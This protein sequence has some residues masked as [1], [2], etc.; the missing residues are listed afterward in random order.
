MVKGVY[1]L[2]LVVLIY[3]NINT[4]LYAKGDDKYG[5]TFK[6]HEVNKD[7][8]T[9][10]NLTPDATMDLS[11]GFELDFDLKL[12]AGVHTYGY[13]FRLI[14][15]DT[16]SLDMVTDINLNQLN[17]ILTDYNHFEALSDFKG[18]IKKSEWIK[19]VF[20]V[21]QDSIHYS[22]DGVSR[23]IDRSITDFDNIKIYFGTN[24][25]ENFYT[26]DLPP[27]AV[28]NIVIKDLDSNILKSWNMGRH[29]SDDV[30]DIVENDRAVAHNGI[31]E[32]DKYANWNKELSIKV[33][34]EYPQLAVDSVNAR[35]FVVKKDSIFIIHI[36]DKRIE[37]IGTKGGDPYLQFF[38]FL[39]YDQNKDRLV[40]YNIDH[41][42]LIY[43][44]FITR[45]WNGSKLDQNQKYMYHNKLVL[46]EKNQLVTFGGYGYYKYSAY[47]C[48]HDLDGAGWDKIDL[49]KD[50]YPRYLASMG[51][52]GDDKLLVFGGYGS[53]SGIQ[54]E[55]ARNLYD[56]FQI[57]LHDYKCTKLGE[58][59]VTASPLAFSNSMII[60]KKHQ[61]FYTLSYSNFNYQTYIKLTEVNVNNLEY[62]FLADSIPYKFTDTQAYCDLFRYNKSQTLYSLVLQKDLDGLYDLS[63]YSVKY[64]ALT[65]AEVTI[66]AKTKNS[67]NYILVLVLVIVLV[68]LFV[69][70]IARKKYLHKT[71]ENTEPEKQIIK[72]PV[73]VEKNTSTIK[74]LGGY[75]VFDKNGNDISG[76]FTP[77]L[78]QIFLMCLLDTII[79]GKG[80]TSDFLD[81]ELWY[82]MDKDKAANNRR[83]NFSKL[84]LLLHEVGDITLKKKNG[85]WQVN[86][87]QDVY[88]DFAEIMEEINLLKQSDQIDKSIVDNIISKAIKGKLIPNIS[89][90]WTD[91]Y[92]SYYTSIIIENMM[93]LAA[94]TNIKNDLK[95]LVNIAEVILIHDNIDEEAIHL[96]CNSLYKLGQKGLSK[97]CFEKYTADYKTLLNEEPNL[98]YE[99]LISD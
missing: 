71:P 74:L 3:C 76:Q 6:S 82:D 80:V 77:I 43:F 97:Q 11:D 5:L 29:C 69:L 67:F 30:Y 94:H 15:S 61:N 88:C 20:K 48:I 65:Y 70:I 96:K 53:K 51:Y 33:N 78:R 87:G 47:L 1:V 73:I 7:Y 90:E 32:I 66:P 41:N 14:S 42:K 25:H 2:F 59:K 92:K 36:P 12:K 40:S 62:R 93:I 39:V 8:R 95:Q 27:M 17:V 9:S 24:N 98:K 21:Y 35:V 22:I 57:D 4:Q 49:K 89:N 46:P 50:V 68:L 75:Q 45:T 91:K 81:E 72:Q 58:T 79:Y 64:P 23:T 37:K 38:N 28:K 56:L 10:L 63:I 19:V 16:T 84:R 18:H 99:H 83:V 86:L 31:W 13:V 44:D 55:S 54:A 34:E 52:L 85:Y 26:K 60:N